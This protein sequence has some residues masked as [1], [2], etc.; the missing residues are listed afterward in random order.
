MAEILVRVAETDPLDP[1]A[2]HPG[3]PIKVRPDGFQWGTREGPPNWCVVRVPDAVALRVAFEAPDVE[4]VEGVKISYRHRKYRF[5]I[6]ALPQLIRDQIAT[7]RV[8]LETDEK[9]ELARGLLKLRDG[10]PGD[11]GGGTLDRKTFGR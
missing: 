7:G 10:S 4:V 6:P 5:D 1:L 11:P 8:D 9:W 3:D 2:H